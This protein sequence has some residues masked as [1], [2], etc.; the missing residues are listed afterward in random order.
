M[1]LQ[2]EG[3]RAL[4]TGSSSGI[5][6]TAAQLLAA[7][8]VAVAVHGRDATRAEAVAADIRAAGGTAIVAI[9]DLGDGEQARAVCETVDR[10]FDGVDIV[11]NNAGGRNA[12][13][14]ATAPFLDIEPADWLSTYN[15]NVVSTVRMIHHFAPAMVEQGWGRFIQNASAAATSPSPMLNDYAAAK[16]AI[17]NLTVG[18]ARA[19]AGTGVTSNAVS[20]GLTMTPSVMGEYMTRYANDQGWDPTLPLDELEYRWARHRGL[21]TKGGG[22]VE[23]LASLVVWLASPLGG[24]A[25]GTN[26]RVDGGQNHNVN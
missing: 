14:P 1:D 15:Q 10:E 5:G 20:P 17:L 11:F 22:R 24:Y 13:A 4:V 23:N 6:A 12:T 3:K 7:E 25:N 8:G 16:A 9:G 2:L 18:L 26:F 21:S 19:L